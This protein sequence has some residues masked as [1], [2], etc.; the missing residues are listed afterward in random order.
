MAARFWVGGA[1][2]WDTTTTTNWSA[3]SGGA[4]GASAP[5]T[6]DTVTFDALSGTGVVTTA[7]GA[8][9]S[10][11]TYNSTTLTSLTL[12]AN[13]TLGGT[14]TFTLTTGAISLASFTLSCTSF[15]GS[16]TATRSI[17]FGTGNITT[18][19]SGTA[20]S[21][22]TL[23][24]FSYTGTPT[25]NISNSGATATTITNGTVG[26][27]EANAVNFNITTGSYSLTI[28]TTGVIKSLNFTGFTGTWA[29]ST[30]TCTFYGSITLVSGMT[31]TTGSG[32]WVLG[33]TSGTQVITS[34]GK[35]LY[36]L[37]QNGGSTVQLA[38]N[39]TLT[40]QYSFAV[41]TL[42][43]TSGSLTC[44]NFLSNTSSTRVINFSTNNITCTTGSF[45]M[46]G[47]VNFSYTGTPSIYITYTGATAINLFVGQSGGTTESN[48]LDFY[49]NGAGATYTVLFGSGSIVRNLNFTGF[50]GTWAQGSNIL[51]FWGNVTLSAGMTVTPNIAAII[52]IKTSGTQTLT[53]AGKTLGL[54]TMNGP[55]GTLQLQAGT[56]TLSTGST[57]TLTAGTLDLGT[58]SSTLSCG[59]FAS[60]ST[61][62][63]VLGFGA[64]G[65]IILT[66]N[67]TTVFNNSTST[68]FS[69]SG[70]VKI[71]STPAV[72]SGTR[73]FSFSTTTSSLFTVSAGT[74]TQVSFGTTGGDSVA[75][76]GQVPSL[77]FTGYLGTWNQGINAMTITTGNLTLDPSMSTT[78]SLTGV[79]TFS[80]TSGTQIISTAGKTINQVTQNG[81]G[82]TVQLGS[83][84]TI[85]SSG[86]YT[87]SAGNLN[88]N[89]FTLTTS[90]FSSSVAATRVLSF[91]TG[92]ITLT[93]ASIATSFTVLGTNLTYTGTPSVYLSSTGS[94]TSTLSPT[95]FIAS[96]AFDFYITSGSYSLTVA[97]NSIL[98]NLDCT[99]FSGTFAK[100]GTVSVYGN[101]TLSSTMTVTGAS[102]LSTVATSGT[103]TIACNGTNIGI[104]TFNGAGGTVTPIQNF[105]GSTVTLTTGTFNANGYDIYITTSFSSSNSNSRTLTMGS[106]S[107]NITS[108]AVTVWDLGTPTNLTF[109]RNTANIFLT[110]SAP[111]VSSF[112]SGGRQYNDITCL[113]STNPFTLNFSGNP[114]INTLTMSRTYPS[115]ISFSTSSTAII[116]TL[117]MSGS[118]GNLVTLRC[119]SVT[120]LPS[121]IPTIA[122]NNSATLDYAVVVDL[123]I[124]TNNITVTNGYVSPT[125][126]GVSLGSNTQGISV[127]ASGTKWTVPTNFSSTN[128]IHAIGAGGGS[129][130]VSISSSSTNIKCGGPGSGGGGYAQAINQSYSVGT[131]VY[132][133][134]GQFG[135]AAQGNA[136]GGL[137]A[138]GNGGSTQFGG[139]TIVSPSY[140]QSL[141]SQQTSAAT[142][143][144][145]NIP[146]T[147]SN[148]NLM[149][150]VVNSSSNTS[151]WELPSGWNVGNYIGNGMAVFW[152]IA[153]SEPASYT[154]TQ[155]VSSTSNA[156]ILEYSNASFSKTTTATGAA[157]T[158]I[159]PSLLAL[160]FYEAPGTTIVYVGATNAASTS[161][162]TPTGYTSR[163]SDTDANAPSMSIFDQSGVT[164]ATSVYSPPSTTVTG[165]N[166]WAFLIALSPVSNWNLKASGGTGSSSYAGTTLVAGVGGTGSGSALNFG[167]TGGTG[168]LPGTTTTGN[169]VSGAG[170]G[171]AA[172]PLGNGANGGN[173]MSGTS[174]NIS[175]GGGGGNGGGSAGG[176]AS[177]TFSGAGGNNAVGFGGGASQ[178]TTSPV[179]GSAGVS[180]GGAS[181]SAGNIGSSVAPGGQGVDIVSM[182]GGAGGN[183]G[184]LANSGPITNTSQTFYGNGTGGGGTNSTTAQAGGSGGNGLIIIMWVPGGGGAYTG[185]VTENISLADIRS[186]LSSYNISR[187]ENSDIQDT[188]NI[189]SA[190]SQSRTEDVNLNDLNS[191]TTNFNL[192][193]SE[194][195]TLNDIEN[196]NTDYNN[197][198]IS[199]NV[200]LNS[201]QVSVGNF[202]KS[203][204][205][206]MTL[207]DLKT[208]GANF[209]RS[210]SEDI[211]LNDAND[212]FVFFAENVNLKDVQSVKADYVVS[213]LENIGLLDTAI[214]SGWIRI[215]DD[216]SISWNNV[217]NA[218]SSTWTD[219]NNDNSSTWVNINNT[220]GTSWTE[221]NN[222]NLNP[223]DEINNSQ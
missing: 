33:G 214:T 161:F 146:A 19:G 170:G 205:E 201:V 182:Y 22:G 12:G 198:I 128:T 78:P 169:N 93:G 192:L 174:P 48:A 111:S 130:G 79:I 44:G 204:V 91:G 5:T 69:T 176:N 216:Q 195:S 203:V 58:N 18:T 137:S 196:V 222:D 115:A 141:L 65:Q 53:T 47:Q 64:S 56:T 194:N 102:A 90:N 63:R 39:T 28:T 71:T 38:A 20:W 52:F 143:I 155:S 197:N 60:F 2:T 43:L 172:G 81:A 42:D 138:G 125:C 104:I 4:G 215:N 15:A 159:T 112:S 11:V 118:S 147:V 148:G 149:I 145:A 51:S 127:L 162:S 181:G 92:N 120:P 87:W 193:K 34:A 57:F 183:G 95:S 40:S 212:A 55:G 180:G 101:I 210:I 17:A 27:T 77:D 190:Y 219:V 107:W 166:G 117:V 177:S 139:T 178:P 186:I 129:A 13:L 83:A 160:S 75:F 122:I 9:A 50:T 80:A 25:V 45:S 70:T 85:V 23:T 3:T 100:A 124:S 134:I 184:G 114:T 173:G 59:I 220:S 153:N 103:Q 121:Q 36:A 152:R 46:S 200:N 10:S 157:A 61:N 14:G 73:T 165:T 171:G 175:S 66:G 167:Y 168:G 54:V 191:L 163:A 82:G 154:V 37:T 207:D 209:L 188:R 88:L 24:G 86:F 31:F 98:R 221:V 187:T 189:L 96:N 1:G 6:A 206:S 142:T 106:G 218:S 89:N 131:T 211:I 185:S 94:V 108:A 49:I 72:Y 151:L 158:T 199:E 133:E 30:A 126:T 223:W 150:L 7:A 123:N 164:S 105:Y 68:N 132:Y 179:S 67:N 16:G 140:I 156:Y 35:N 119:A 217:N 32:V 116:N 74:G 113:N 213:M 41:G 21:M 135:V 99:G 208:A 76:V 29:P 110:L 136:L 8:T 144:T 97:T 84:L 202:V 109:N 62:V 26:G